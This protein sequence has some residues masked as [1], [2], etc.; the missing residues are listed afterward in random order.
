M[1]ARRATNC[2]AICIV[3][4][5]PM[6]TLA[7]SAI[8]TDGTLGASVALDGLDV[9]IPA[10]L[11]QTR[12]GNLF[13]SFERFN[14]NT[15][16]SATFTGPDGLNHVISRVTGGTI[17]AIDGTLASRIE[18]ADVWLI[19]PAGVLFGPDARLNVPAGFHVST[20]NE[21]RFGDGST[22]SASNPGGSTLT[23]AEPASFGFLGTTPG[24]IGLF[25]AALNLRSEQA[26]SLVGGDIGI[27]GNGDS[28]L[29][30]RDG[31]IR[32][33]A[34]E[35]A[36]SVSLDPNE[37]LPPGRRAITLIE[38]ASI[39]TAGARGGPI[40]V[41]G[42]T[43][44]VRE[45]SE[46]RTVR[47]GE[48]ISDNHVIVRADSLTLDDGLI[49]TSTLSV[50]DAGDLNV[51]TAQLALINGG[52]LES[53]T[54]SEGNAGAITIDANEISVI[55]AG[56]SGDTGIIA[57]AGPGSTGNAGRIQIDTQELTLRDGGAIESGTSTSG[58]AG[59][60]RVDATS[61]LIER[62]DTVRPTG[63]F[64]DAG[65]S[66]TSDAGLIQVHA[67][68]LT[69]NDGGSIASETNGNA[70]GGTVQ[71]VADR[72]LLDGRFGVGTSIRADARSSSQ[73]DAGQVQIHA[74]SIDLLRG[75][76]IRAETS[77]GGSAGRIDIVADRL[78]LDAE[79]DSVTRISVSTSPNSTGA[80]GR[81]VL[82]IG[83]LD[84]RGGATLSGGTSG[85]GRAGTI[86][87]T[88]DT[89][90]ID[91]DGADGQT[92]ILSQTGF[93]ASGGGG[94]IQVTATDIE[95]FGSGQIG[96]STFGSG[97]A[98]SIII[99][100]NSLVSDGQGIGTGGIN[101]TSST[102]ST[103]GSGAIDV[104]ADEIGLRN[105][106]SIN[107]TMFGQGDSQGISIRVGSL[108]IDGAD[109]GAITAVSSSTGAGTIG[110]AGDIMI[111]A[112][113]I[114]VLGDGQ[115][116]SD[117]N[118][119]GNGGTINIIADEILL[120]GRGTNFLAGILSESGGDATG[121]GGVINITAGS[122]EVRDSIRIAS[123][124]FSGAPA[125]QVNIA[126]DHIIVDGS[127][128]FDTSISSEASSFGGSA[129]QIDISA[130]NLDLRRGGR[131]TS[132]TFGSG[133]AG[134]VAINGGTIRLT[135]QST[136]ESSSLL[137]GG[138]AGDI[139]IF[140]KQILAQD[141]SIRTTGAGAAGG[142]IDTTARQAI[143]FTNSEI[144]TSGDLPAPGA[145]ILTLTA[146]FIEILAASRMLSLAGDTPAVPNGGIRTGAA[147][148]AGVITVISDDSEIAASTDVDVQGLDSEFGSGL[149]LS[150]A[151]TIDIDRLLSAAC[152]IQGDSDATSS[153]A[154][155]GQAQP[156]SPTGMLFS[157]AAVNEPKAEC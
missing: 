134:A 67:E 81:L 77:A 145:S 3:A 74:G 102:F 86:I 139:R 103:G 90:R 30:A 106:G 143:R 148:V 39:S 37:P 98:G 27:I 41:D 107:T 26:L 135:G 137:A 5:W 78:T 100:T 35:G 48:G 115:I 96:T 53:G 72:L 130:G 34:V 19:N 59:A 60:I 88:A 119:A 24:P 11:G 149:Q 91:S 123:R 33:A 51:D 97:N 95:L 54:F 25:G 151:T 140:A 6:Q 61:V 20:A 17:S 111:N 128:G 121:A 68:N 79:D 82:D 80:G 138:S 31:S 63:L 9:D 156:S 133:N 73:G 112:G 129:G 71:I 144:T 93:D 142:R 83:A 147:L 44:A 69:L 21:L 118:G 122:L 157:G 8:A 23:I 2:L 105:G 12:G 28:S 155:A 70:N 7:Q 66:A 136:I 126:A 116:D 64:T 62:G 46:I 124:T 47:F 40:V 89:L 87:V 16:G 85:T 152:A 36:G 4:A 45:G 55:G 18:G 110:D 84:V 108:T 52:L 92:G 49:S 29:L 154:R 76:G 38:Q 13:H 15:G 58:Q 146:P 42:G 101:S 132:S 57:S 131:I 10:E 32:L 127:N 117:T 14:I 113:S 114:T 50:G 94:L 65:L 104:H 56:A 120:D 125:G 141:S 75:G 22:F 153:F 99:D 109:G 150:E 1:S 43:I